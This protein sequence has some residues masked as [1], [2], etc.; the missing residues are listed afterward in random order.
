VLALDAQQ[1]RRERV[2][3][4][5]LDRV[6]DD[7]EAVP[8]DLGEVGGD[9][10]AVDGETLRAPGCRRRAPAST[11]EQI[12][13]RPLRAPAESRGRVERPCVGGG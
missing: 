6:G 9:A 5:R 8:L 1:V 2:A 4:R 12:T 7:R 11:R 13:P 3:E 10:F